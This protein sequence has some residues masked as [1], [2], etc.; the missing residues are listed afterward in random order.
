MFFT[1][2]IF[3]FFAGISFSGMLLAKSDDTLLGKSPDGAITIQR[4]HAAG[5]GQY[6]DFIDSR[7]R[8]VLFSFRSAWRSTE[9]I[10]EKQGQLLCINDK[11]ATSGDYVYIFRIGPGRKIA[12]LRHPNCEDF[13]F[14]L[15]QILKKQPDPGR[16]TFIGEKWLPD[17]RLLALVSGGYYGDGRFETI[18]QVNSSGEIEVIQPKR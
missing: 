12:L 14:N 5:Q 2:L 9:L 7:T 16:F 17:H 10:W 15:L 4:R 3:I 8:E 18:L 11:I 13:A 6:V 1:R